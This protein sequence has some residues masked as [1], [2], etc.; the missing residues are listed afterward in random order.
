MFEPSLFTRAIAAW[1]IGATWLGL[2]LLDAAGLPE[3]VVPD[4]Q[5][6]IKGEGFAAGRGM[7][8]VYKRWVRLSEENESALPEIEYHVSWDP[9]GEV[10]SIYDMEKEKGGR[11]D[12]AE[13]CE[14]Q[15]AWE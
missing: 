12:E 15:S 10:A 14:Q 2:R 1:K 13:I 9:A 8:T 6:F 7:V 5:L 11:Y 3:F 4:A